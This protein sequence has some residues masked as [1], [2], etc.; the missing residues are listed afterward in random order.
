MLTPNKRGN[1]DLTVTGAFD[2]LDE[3]AKFEGG[4]EIRSVH[5]FNLQ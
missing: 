1:D 4:T 2:I 3:M 5:H